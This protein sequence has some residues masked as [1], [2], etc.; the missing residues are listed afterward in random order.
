VTYTDIDNH[1]QVIKSK[2]N[3]KYLDLTVSKCDNEIQDLD[4]L[5]MHNLNIR[6][7]ESLDSQFKKLIL[8]KLPCKMATELM[9]SDVSTV[10]K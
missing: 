8:T 2:L 7:L 1:Y 3:L 6:R 10:G 4:I 9:C 5:I